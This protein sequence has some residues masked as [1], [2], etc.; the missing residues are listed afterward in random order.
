MKVL[1]LEKDAPFPLELRCSTTPLKGGVKVLV[2][3]I[4]HDGYR[5]HQSIPFPLDVIGARY[6]HRLMGVLG[7]LTDADWLYRFAPTRRLMNILANGLVIPMI[8][9]EVLTPFEV[10]NMVHRLE[11]EGHLMAVGICECRHG[12]KNTTDELDDGKDPNYTCVMI[13]DWGRGHLYNYPSQYRRTNAGELSHLA[14]FWHRRGRVITAWGCNT[15]HGFMASYCHCLPD[16][17]VPFRNQLKRGN[18]V[19]LKGYSLAVIDP[20]RCMGPD[21]CE[22]NCPSR[23]HFGAITISGGK[24]VVNPEMCFGCGLCFE[25]CPTGAAVPTPRREHTLYYCPPDLVSPMD[26]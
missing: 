23:C 22:W 8:H 26:G 12:E 25:H 10:G 3:H 6:E 16:Y 20:D 2:G 9:G 15:V 1:S 18:Q 13:G 19:F 21:R 4:N 24:P 11:A 5:L 17:C 7:K 14:R